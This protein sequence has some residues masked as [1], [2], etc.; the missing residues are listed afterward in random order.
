L[1]KVGIDFGI[2]GAFEFY[3]SVFD[4]E[5]IDNLVKQ[6]RMDLGVNIIDNHFHPLFAAL[7]V[8]VNV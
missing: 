1:Y 4:F 3:D 6:T 8:G 7:V 5:R 2:G